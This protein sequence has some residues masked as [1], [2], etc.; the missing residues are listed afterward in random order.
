MSE[1]RISIF[2]QLF[3]PE[4]SWS[5]D[6]LPDQTGKVA[7][8][9]GGIRGVGKETARVTIPCSRYILAPR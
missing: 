9:T 4:P 5:V 2:R 8:I 6:S 3:P 1:R 7:I